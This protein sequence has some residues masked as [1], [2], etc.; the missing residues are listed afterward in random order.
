MSNVELGSQLADRLELLRSRHHLSIAA[1]ARQAG[2][3]ARTM[4][5]YFKGKLP[6]VSGLISLSRGLSVD[7]DW[8]LGIEPEHGNYAGDIIQDAGWNLFR[9][10]AHQILAKHR[11]G[12]PI[13]EGDSVL[14][15]T[16]EDFAAQYSSR[17]RMNHVELRRSE[18]AGGRKAFNATMDR[19]AR[20]VES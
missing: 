3:P 15:M 10:I 5:N 16:P 13:V 14:G 8:L 6:N 2:I 7:I 18:I 4:E 19:Q 17:L 1:F 11:N 9:E 12:L 20:E